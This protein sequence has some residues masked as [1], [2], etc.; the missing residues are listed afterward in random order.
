MQV[1]MIIWQFTMICINYFNGK[2]SHW[3]GGNVLSSQ[4]TYSRFFSFLISSTKWKK[5]NCLEVIYWAMRFTHQTQCNDVFQNDRIGGCRR[6][7]IDTFGKQFI[8]AYCSLPQ[9]LITPTI[10]LI[11]RKTSLSSFH[12]F[13]A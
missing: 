2:K 6:R 7:R 1:Q 9:S 11:K 13:T 5:K 3:M 12:L 8:R 10:I 4:I